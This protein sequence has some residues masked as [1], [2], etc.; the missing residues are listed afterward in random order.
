MIF[1]D[2]MS[3]NSLKTNVT[4]FSGIRGNR[5]DAQALKICVTREGTGFETLVFEAYLLSVEATDLD[6]VSKVTLLP[7]SSNNNWN[8]QTSSDNIAG[9]GRA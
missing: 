2:V 3:Y 7:V 5:E 6:L 8:D 1:D 9:N 4:H